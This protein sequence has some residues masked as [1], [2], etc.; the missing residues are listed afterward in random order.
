M[1]DRKFNLLGSKKRFLQLLISLKN[2]VKHQ[3]RKKRK[4]KFKNKKSKKIKKKV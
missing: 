4:N 1:E 3:D 2:K